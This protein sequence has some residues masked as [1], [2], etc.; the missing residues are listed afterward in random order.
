MSS[1]TADDVVP[2]DDVVPAADR[3]E[4]DLDDGIVRELGHDEYTP[5]GTLVLVAIYAA[6]LVFMWSFM[7]FVEFLNNGPTVV[8]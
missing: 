8:G 6:I 2:E 7:Y 3:G 1:G 5:I 4:V